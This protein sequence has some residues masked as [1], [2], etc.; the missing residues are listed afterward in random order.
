MILVCNLGNNVPANISNPVICQ[1]FQ[2]PPHFFG[3]CSK[4]TSFSPRVLKD[5]LAPNWS[6]LS[7]LAHFNPFFTSS[8]NNIFQMLMRLCYS[9]LKFCFQLN[10]IKS[11]FLNFAIN[12]C[13][14]FGPLSFSTRYV[15]FPFQIVHSQVCF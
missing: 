1:L 15:S 10:L 13:R 12:S 8:Q 7:I 11:K 3:S 9:L 5:C 6:L 2:I 4:P 14:L